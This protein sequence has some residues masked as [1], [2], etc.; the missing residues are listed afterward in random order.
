MP[1]VPHL[2]ADRAR[3]GSLNS[4]APKPKISGPHSNP[5]HGPTR[6]DNPAQSLCA[7][8]SLG[9]SPVGSWTDLRFANS[10]SASTGQQT[11]IFL[12][13]L[14]GSKGVLLASKELTARTGRRPALG[15]QRQTKPVSP[16]ARQG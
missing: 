10:V 12:K 5:P 2:G 7:H 4:L 1:K 13:H 14:P 9:V 11:S 8:L 15:K 3:I 16:C 6:E